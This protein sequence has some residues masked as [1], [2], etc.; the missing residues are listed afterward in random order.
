MIAHGWLKGMERIFKVIP[1]INEEKVVFA[2]HMLKGVEERW[3]NG[4]ADFMT[5]RSI[6]KD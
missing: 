3:K 4:V 5:A 6:P 1:C 2:T